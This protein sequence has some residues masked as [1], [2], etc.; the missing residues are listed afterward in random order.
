MKPQLN[1]LSPA[2]LASCTQPRDTV[3]ATVAYINDVLADPQLRAR[4]GREFNQG[5]CFSM[6]YNIDLTL[7]QARQ[8]L[9]VCE[10]SGWKNVQVLYSKGVVTVN[11]CNEGHPYWTSNYIG[12]PFSAAASMPVLMAA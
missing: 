6:D 1:I 4:H 3:A 7:D 12:L 10:R 8:L 2:D 9:T 11:L 5:I